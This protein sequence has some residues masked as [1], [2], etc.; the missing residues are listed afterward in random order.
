MCN[1]YSY[2]DYSKFSYIQKIHDYQNLLKSQRF[3]LEN[4]CLF[5]IKKGLIIYKS[6]QMGTFNL[7]TNTFILH[8]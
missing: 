8:D 1:F 2:S 6:S 4:K 7:H 3:F 5:L